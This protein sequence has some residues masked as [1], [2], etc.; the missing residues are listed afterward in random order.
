DSNLTFWLPA[1]RIKSAVRGLPG[2]SVPTHVNCSEVI[3]VGLSFRCARRRRPV[4]AASV[5]LYSGG[6]V[7]AIF[8]SVQIASRA[9]VSG[10]RAGRLG[11]VAE[12]VCISLS[13]YLGFSGDV[14]MVCSGA[15]P[16]SG[17]ARAHEAS[18]DHGLGGSHFCLF[19]SAQQFCGL[20]GL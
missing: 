8:W 9:L 7:A 1:A 16:R 18:V 4:Y 12:Q 11:L 15:G 20:G 10:G 5:A 3:H 17:A 14:G 19:L 2:S 6:C 13:V